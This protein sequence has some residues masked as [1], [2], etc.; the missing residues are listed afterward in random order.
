M[1]VFAFA[2]MTF[3]TR[4]FFSFFLPFFLL[5]LSLLLQWRKESSSWCCCWWT[6]TLFIFL[7]W[8]R[9][10]ND[11]ADWHF[12]WQTTRKKTE[13]ERNEEN[14]CT[15]FSLSHLFNPSPWRTTAAW[16]DPSG[17]NYLVKSV[18]LEIAWP[19]YPN[20]S[21]REEYW[22]LFFW[23]S[24]RS[25]DRFSFPFSWPSADRG[26]CVPLSFQLTRIDGRTEREKE[27]RERELSVFSHSPSFFFLFPSFSPAPSPTSEHSD[28]KNR[29]FYA[30]ASNY[31]WM[32]ISSRSRLSLSPL[33]LCSLDDRLNLC[34][35]AQRSKAE[36]NRQTDMHTPASVLQ[37]CP[38]VIR[39]IVHLLFQIPTRWEDQR[40]LLV[41]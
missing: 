24:D 11:S 20:K 31:I 15:F 1:F 22:L 6:F 23:S 38:R 30:G 19:V 14:F 16:L 28:N 40:C 7:C 21:I 3:F 35:R 8:Q 39:F 26:E 25:I 12:P 4:W 41:R 13:G 9:R 2:F 17:N 5:F 10:S 37:Q 36:Q 33:S 32:Y 34:V 29:S 18:G 27:R